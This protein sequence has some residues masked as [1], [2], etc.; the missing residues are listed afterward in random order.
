MD[1]PQVARWR[2]GDAQVPDLEMLKIT[3]Q[4]EILLGLGGHEK[5]GRTKDGFHQQ[6]TIMFG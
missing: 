5:R 4:E 2:T 3:I 6:K 1:T